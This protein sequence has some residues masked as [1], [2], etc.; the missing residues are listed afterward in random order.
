M[1]S[2]RPNFQAADLSADS[3]E[4]FYLILNRLFSK[5]VVTIKVMILRSSASLMICG[6]DTYLCKGFDVYLVV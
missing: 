1:R 3:N 4:S 5:N 6:F 2:G